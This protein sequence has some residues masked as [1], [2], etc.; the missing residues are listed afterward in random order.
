LL[1][2]TQDG[3][4]ILA[5]KSSGGPVSALT[6]SRDGRFLAFGTE[7]GAAGVLDMA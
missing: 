6:W 4:E 3:A 1:V 2:R 5:R 7:D